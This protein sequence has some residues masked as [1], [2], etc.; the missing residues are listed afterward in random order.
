MLQYYEHTEPV[1]LSVDALSKGLETVLL[2]DGKPITALTAAQQNYAQIEREALAISY[3]CTK[4][5]QCVWKRNT[6]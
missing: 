6:C 5:L 2:Q 3:G 1:T 4:F